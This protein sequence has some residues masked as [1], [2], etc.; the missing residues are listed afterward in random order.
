MCR[1]ERI[2][3]EFTVHRAVVHLPPD[4]CTDMAGCIAIIRRIDPRVREIQTVAG[5]VPDTRYVCTEGVWRSVPPP[6]CSHGT[7]PRDSGRGWRRSGSG[8][9]DHP[10]AAAELDSR[11]AVALRDL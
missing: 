4:N 7:R 5:G 9:A 10:L 3:V 8:R 11:E 6:A 2:E 1:V